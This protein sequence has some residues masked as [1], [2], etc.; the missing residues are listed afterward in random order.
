[1]Q[2]QDSGFYQV[3]FIKD[4]ERKKQRFDIVVGIGTQAQS[5]MSWLKKSL[6]QLPVTYFTNAH[7]WSNSPGY[8]DK[9]AFDRP[10]TS[11][12]LECHSSYAKVISAPEKEPEEYDK[13]RMILGINCEKCHGP[14]AAHVKFQAENPTIKT[15]KF[16]LN[17]AKFTR[18]Q[19]LDMCAVCH[20]GRLEKSK[21]SFQFTP[22]DKL[23][24]YF[25][26]D[27]TPKDVNNLDVHA[28]N[29]VY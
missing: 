26:I 14:A 29:T 5:Y 20:G 17:P 25:L 3:G 10:I 18:R 28:T 23:T 13:S 8:P 2:K 21:P 11:R 9:I 27:S 19:S 24:D 12:C 4:I 16:I 1:M 15:A 7:Q 22:G 6:M